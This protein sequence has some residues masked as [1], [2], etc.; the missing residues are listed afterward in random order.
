[1]DG[2][3]GTENGRGRIALQV[4]RYGLELGVS[5]DVDDRSS[6][7]RWIKGCSTPETGERADGEG[8]KIK[9]RA[10][11]WSGGGTAA[12]CQS[13][14]RTVEGRQRCGQKGILRDALIVG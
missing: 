12:G 14:S 7:E 11:G 6:W 4:D 3:G 2:S 1:N 10:G 9:I 13:R 8:R 5:I